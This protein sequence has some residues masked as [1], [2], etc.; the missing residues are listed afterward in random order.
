MLFT[1]NALL[2]TTLGAFVGKYLA[3]VVHYLPPMLL[4]ETDK[5]KEPND[6]L[7]RF[8]QKPHCGNC[9]GAI[10]WWDNAPIY[11]YLSLKGRCPLCNHPLGIKVL[12]LEVGTALLFGAS[13]LFFPFDT[14][15][16]FVLIACCLLLCCFF[17]DFEH[18]IL[19][20][21]FTISLVWLGLIGSLFP[22]FLTPKEAIMGAV[23]GYGI[24]WFFNLIYS[25][26]RG[27]EGMY[28]GDFKLNAGIGACVGLPWLF[29]ILIISFI[30]LLA[31]TV[32]QFLFFKRTINKSILKQEAPYGCYSSIVTGVALYSILSGTLI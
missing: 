13:V 26:L 20:D 16:F 4:D 22:I 27:F 15:L 14:T 24:L 21:Q 6:I 23:G 17:T 25:Y 31:F 7:K 12:V 30:F 1:F 2:A 11:G 9:Q 32:L 3:M 28:P 10:S 18:G 8:F 5:E 29:V 19:P